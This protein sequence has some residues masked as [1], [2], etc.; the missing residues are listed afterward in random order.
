MYSTVSTLQ[1]A[2]RCKVA[3]ARKNVYKKRL[4][5]VLSLS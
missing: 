2:L 4:F 3:I 1:L 5:Q